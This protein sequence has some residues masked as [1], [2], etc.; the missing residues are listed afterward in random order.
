MFVL[1]KFVNENVVVLMECDKVLR[2]FCGECWS[3]SNEAMIYPL[4][5]PP[6]HRAAGKAEKP[7][8]RN[9]VHLDEI[10]GYPR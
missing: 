9:G 5:E 2:V 1:L 4:I 6:P 10:H 8:R 7:S 3:A